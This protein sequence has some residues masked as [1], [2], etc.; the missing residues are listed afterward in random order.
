MPTGSVYLVFKDG[1]KENIMI[2]DLINPRKEIMNDE[3]IMG[4]V[5]RYGY[6]KID[7]IVYER[8]G[9]VTKVPM[10]DYYYENAKKLKEEK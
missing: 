5:K 8:H 9:R 10:A 6:D 2:T 1:K 3:H 7:S 4:W